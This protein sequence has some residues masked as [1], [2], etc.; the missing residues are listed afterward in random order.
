MDPGQA[1]VDPGQAYVDPGQAY[2]DPGQAYVDPGQAYVD[3]NAAQGV[4]D[5]VPVAASAGSGPSVS[6]RQKK[7][8]ARRRPNAKP[9]TP[10]QRAGAPGSKYASSKRTYGGGVS[11][12]SVLLTLVALAMLGAVVLVMLPGDTSRL[13]AYPVNP[14]TSAKPANLLGETQKVMLERK[15]N[16]S[17]TEEQVNQYLNHRLQGVQ[18]GAVSS[19][20]KFKGVYVDFSPGVAEIF[21]IREF[22]GMPITIT[23]KI[24]PTKSR[25][26]MNY[27]PTGW[28]LGRVDLGKRSIK[29]VVQLFLRLR[30]ACLEEYQTIQ[31]MTDVRFEDN[32]IIL[33]SVI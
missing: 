6:K 16:V 15:T 17:F 7:K 12:M 14:I 21:I 8:V 9:L 28:T 26:L 10:R 22:F 4:Y 2:V 25:N 1:Y 19:F 24:T 27:H 20:V 11:M 29:P 13:A 18:G 31:Q 30:S 3:P 32:L 23:S 33:D 5:E